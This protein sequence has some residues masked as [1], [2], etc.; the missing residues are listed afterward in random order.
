MIDR[1][2]YKDKS[3]WHLDGHKTIDMVY[4]YISSD[5]NIVKHS[6]YPF[7]H[8]EMKFNKFN[9]KKNNGK[10]KAKIRQIFY[11]SHIDRYIYQR[12]GSYYNDCYNTYCQEK[13]FDK[14]SIAY[15]NNKK[16]KCNIHFAKDVFRFIKERENCFIMVGDFTNFFDNLDHKYLKD[17]LCTVSNQQKLTDAQYKVYKSITRFSYLDITDIANFLCILQKKIT[18][19][20]PKLTTTQLHDLKK[21]YLK[22]NK[23]DK[24]NWK[25]Y[26]IPQGSPISAIFA[27]VYM[28][29]FDEKLNEFTKQQKGLYRRYSDD[30][31]IVIPNIKQ[32]EYE[33][34]ADKIMEVVNN[35]PNL[36]L[37]NKKTAFY[38]FNQKKL[39]PINN[40]LPEQIN[41]SSQ[42]NFLGFSFDG[43]N[44]KLRDKTITKYYYKLYSTIDRQIRLELKREFDN[45]K[46]R[47]G[48]KH[49][50]RAIIKKKSKLGAKIINGKGTNFISYVKKCIRLFP[51]EKGIIKVKDRSLDKISK[52]FNVE[53]RLLH[54][55]KL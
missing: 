7:I 12:F 14:C 17:K 44:V 48:V 45:P 20:K 32:E 42:L 30:F 22:H 52:R 16:G 39:T 21:N 5:K 34:I 50:R 25:T 55:D 43:E 1:N 23:D 9:I 54:G 41:E 33:S 19:L 49:R 27:N 38:H 18:T 24:N 26:G 15:R 8:Y 36:T 40:V 6:F 37:E 4:D 3:Y 47:K 29:D 46:N 53:N 31:I 2:I 28:I 51:N 35:T 11:C 10:K 13:G